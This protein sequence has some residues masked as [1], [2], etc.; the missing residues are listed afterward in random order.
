MGCIL[1]WIRNILAV[2]GLITM[3][4]VIIIGGLLYS[5]TRTSS[6]ENNMHDVSITTAAANSYDAK[7]NAFIS[8]APGTVKTL[9]VTEEEMSSKLTDMA[10]ELGLPIDIKKVWVNFS[11]GSVYVD[12]CIKG[13]IFGLD[14][15]VAAEADIEVIEVGSKHVLQY[16]IINYSI[17]DQLK[18]IIDKNIGDKFDLALERNTQ[19]EYD[20]PADWDLL[21]T[22]LTVYEVNAAVGEAEA[23]YGLQITGEIKDS[24]TA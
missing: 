21:P 19:Q 1:G 11:P 20:I 18:K 3:I 14:V 22:N 9:Q 15:S 4:I 13:N 6:I 5:F 16:T 7:W 8:G 24:A 17:P 23:T 2:V 10:G 12:L